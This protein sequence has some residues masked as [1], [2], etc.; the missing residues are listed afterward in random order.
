MATGLLPYGETMMSIS[1]QLKEAIRAYGTLY[2]VAKDS[3]VP[4]SVLQR[5]E[6]GQRDVYL[7]TADR[8]CEFFGMRLTQPTAKRAGQKRAATKGK[9][10]RK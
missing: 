6:A 7:A 2:A 8:L 3:G 1:E 9:G 5:F 4:Y 10:K